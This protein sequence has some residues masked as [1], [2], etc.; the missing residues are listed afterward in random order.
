M[1]PVT[2]I[3]FS[4][5]FGERSWNY[6]HPARC[7][8]VVISC[9]HSSTEMPATELVLYPGQFHGITMPSYQRDRLARYVAW[10]DKYLKK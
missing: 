4:L 2:D 1:L 3:R 6:L 5:R 8:D 9:Q 7:H 10:F